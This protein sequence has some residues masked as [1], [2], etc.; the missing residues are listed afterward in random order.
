MGRGERGKGQGGREKA[1]RGKEGEQGGR[2]RGKCSVRYFIFVQLE[3][4][5]LKYKATQK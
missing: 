4:T 5:T 1:R 3:E 2:E